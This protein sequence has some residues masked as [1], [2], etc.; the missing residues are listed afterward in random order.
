MVIH[1]CHRINMRR[2]LNYRCKIHSFIWLL[3]V[4][5]RT[6][7]QTTPSYFVSWYN[8]MTRRKKAYSATSS[9]EWSISSIKEY[10][11]VYT[12]NRQLIVTG[13]QKYGEIVPKSCFQWTTEAHFCLD[14][15]RRSIFIA[16]LLL[17]LRILKN[18]RLVWLLA[19]LILCFYSQHN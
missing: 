13:R 1:C 3:Y 18:T 15:M 16:R 14:S 7:E 12:N 2:T 11:T 4:Y 5:D 8:C 17:V 19:F 9:N 10:S 6:I